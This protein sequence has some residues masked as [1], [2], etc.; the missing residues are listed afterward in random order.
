MLRKSLHVLSSFTL[1][2]GALM[3]AS[4][5]PDARANAV[6]KINFVS[7]AVEPGE[8]FTI[9]GWDLTETNLSVAVQLASSSP[10]LAGPTTGAYYPEILQTDAKSNYAVAILPD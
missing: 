10:S 8:S 7:D 4:P 6:P 5:A 3:T 1:L 9:T 2:L